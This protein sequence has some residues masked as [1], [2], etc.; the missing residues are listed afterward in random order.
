MKGIFVI[1]T[2][3]DIGK[4]FISSGLFRYLKNRGKNVFPYK[5]IQSGGIIKKGSLIS[6]DI[7]YICEENKIDYDKEMNSYCFKT[8]VSPHLASEIEDIDIELDKIKNHYNRLLE[9]Y[10]FI[11]CEGAG[12]IN[13]PIIRNKYYIYDLI[14]ELNL[15]IILVCSSK[16]GTINHT[17]LTIDKLNALGIKIRGIVV[18]KY[19]N[20]FY[21]KDNLRCIK[22]IS[23]APVVIVKKENDNKKA[24]DEVDFSSFFERG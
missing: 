24:F 17:T 16:V 7:K 9:K 18:N 8:P 21:E 3:T 15:D 14:S 20:E 13:V 11:I 4:T 23:D 1:G 10:E 22:E 19:T 5:P 2:D 6:G 12:G